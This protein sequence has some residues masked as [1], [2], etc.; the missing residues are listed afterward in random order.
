MRRGNRHETCLGINARLPGPY[1]CLS[2]ELSGKLNR[3][4][5][6]DRKGMNSDV[7]CALCVLC[8]YKILNW[9]LVPMQAPL[10]FIHHKGFRH[11]RS[12]SCSAAARTT[13][14]SNSPCRRTPI[15]SPRNT[16]SIFPPKRNS[17]PASNKSPTTWTEGKAMKPGYK[18]TAPRS[19]LSR[20]WD[21]RR[22]QDRIARPLVR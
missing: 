5:R 15:A 11:L 16:S 14:S 13:P 3:M 1:R 10:H 6:R 9:S 7:L 2:W 12:A 22:P 17:R 20:L 21:K 8:G 19:H 18:Q 4:E